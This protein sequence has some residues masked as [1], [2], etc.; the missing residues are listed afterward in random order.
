MTDGASANQALA[1]LTEATAAA[2]RAAEAAEP[3]VAP[4]QTLMVLRSGTRW[5]A[6]PAQAVREVVLKSFITRIPHAPPHVLGVALIRG[7][8]LPVVSLDVLLPATEA[9]AQ[10]AATL[11]RLVVIETEQAEAALVAEEVYGIADFVE[12]SLRDQASPA[13]RPAWVSAEITWQ[14]R[15]L[16]ILHLDRLLHATLGGETEP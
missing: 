1:A 4:T 7:R 11:P 2:R 10:L 13:A 14:Q 5:L 16:C 12:D 8:L 9:R 6:V 15:L 3:V